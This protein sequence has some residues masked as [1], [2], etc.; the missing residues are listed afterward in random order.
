MKKSHLAVLM[1]ALLAVNVSAQAAAPADAKKHS[2]RPNRFLVKHDAN[3]D[4][5]LSKEE[6]MVVHENF[7]KEVDTNKDGKLSNDELVAH[8]QKKRAAR[9]KARAERMAKKKV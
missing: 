6:F 5:F 7:F 9:D 2:P 1:S 3:K 8:N 4:G